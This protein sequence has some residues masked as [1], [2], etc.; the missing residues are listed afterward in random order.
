V[1]S[2]TVAICS[3][4]G[5]DRLAEQLRAIAGLVDAAPESW[6]GSELLVVLDGSD[7][8][9]ESAI[10]SIEIGIP[11]RVHWKTNGGLASARNA[12]LELA[13]GEVIWLLD[14]D[15]FP[16]P[17]AITRHRQA[18]ESRS[19][20]LLLGP[21]EIPDHVVVADGVRRWWDDRHRRL[22]GAGRVKS[23]QDVAMANV[24]CPVAVLREVGGFAEAFVSY[25]MEDNEIG[26]RLLAAGKPFFFDPEA[27][28]WH[29]TTID[30]RG[31]FRRQRILGRNAALFARMHPNLAG[32]DLP[33]GAGMRTVRLLERLPVGVAA[34]EWLLARA[35]YRVMLALRRT[36][37]EKAGHFEA[38]AWDAAYRSGVNSASDAPNGRQPT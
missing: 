34:A 21:C 3:Y 10:S 12:A 13:A 1:R 20:S 36:S 7:D 5:R 15:L 29:H 6:E 17:G 30:E 24:S 23:F 38:F 35:A 28:V 19:D 26:A 27:L 9:S 22:A 37:P 25:G 31:T 18:H 32:A 2:L 16:S 8:G 4:Q 14:D 11:L 33:R